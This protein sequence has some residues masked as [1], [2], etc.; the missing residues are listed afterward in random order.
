MNK[1][2]PGCEVRP[3]TRRAGFVEE[4][5]LQHVAFLER[6]ERAAGPAKTA[7]PLAA[8]QVLS[9][10]AAPVTAAGFETMPKEDRQAFNDALALEATNPR[11]AWT[12]VSPLFE[13][14]PTVRAVQELRCRLAKAR[15]FFPGVVEAHCARL[16]ALAPETGAKGNAGS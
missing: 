6:W 13:A 1:T 9:P 12:L 5:R 10:P 16:G 15:H 7:V 14:H 11:D 2:A 8:E 3:G 4:D